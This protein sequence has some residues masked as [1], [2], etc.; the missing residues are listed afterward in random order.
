MAASDWF[1]T[2]YKLRGHVAVLFLVVIVVALSA[3]H[4]NL[5]I[6]FT[7]AEVM[8]IGMVRIK[9]SDFLTK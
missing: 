1:D 3:A 8:C 7:R 2:R 4:L 5:G 6:I 9:N